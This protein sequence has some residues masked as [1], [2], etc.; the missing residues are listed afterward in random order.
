MSKLFI[1]SI[2]VDSEIICEFAAFCQ[3]PR[4]REQSDNTGL[5]ASLSLGSFKSL[6]G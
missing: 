3:Q 5:I 6:H 1:W 4:L 2:H